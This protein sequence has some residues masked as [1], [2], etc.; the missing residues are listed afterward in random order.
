MLGGVMKV[1]ASAV[2]ALAPYVRQAMIAM[3]GAVGRSPVAPDQLEQV[4]LGFNAFPRE[5]QEEIRQQ[6]LQ[7][8][9]VEGELNPQSLER[10]G[11][12]RSLGLDP[13]TA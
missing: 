2:N 9:R 13:T 11:E 6:A 8:L 3:K 12:M 4:I 7:Q 5:V 10:L 1:G